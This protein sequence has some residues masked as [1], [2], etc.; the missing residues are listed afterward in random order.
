MKSV[1]YNDFK[2]L[3]RVFEPWEIGSYGLCDELK[4][5]DWKILFQLADGFRVLPALYVALERREILGSLDKEV[6]DFLEGVYELNLQHNQLLKREA[7]FVI[8][9]LNSIGIQPI[10]LKGMAGLLS[11]LYEDEAERIIGDID[12]LVN[13]SELPVVLEEMLDHGYICELEICDQVF[14]S[15]FHK[16]ELTLMTE[17]WSVK[18]DLHVRPMGASGSKAFISTDDASDRAEV[19]NLDGAHFLLPSPMFRL[20]H[21]FYHAQ[22]LD[23]SYL[24]SNINLRQLIDWVKLWRCYGSMI[25]ISSMEKKLRIHHQASSFRLYVLNA[26]RYL[27]MPIPTGVKT[28]W[29]EE[30]LFYRQN[31]NLQ[32]HWFCSINRITIYFLYGV[33]MLVVPERLRL[34]YGDLPLRRLIALRIAGLLDFRWY[35]RRL[36]DAR[37]MLWLKK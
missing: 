3:C 26:E 37:K 21:N 29:F 5:V 32:N 33:Q 13:L 15:N 25:D 28:G 35:W 1:D 18:I 9:L 14:N 34:K 11:N 6:Y 24:E 27:G 7:L 12:I 4:N 30:V 8:R 22:Y 19:V 2:L 16:H 17:S 31:L 23:R 10:L 36:E 20:M